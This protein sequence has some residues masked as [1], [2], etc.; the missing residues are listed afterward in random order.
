M[1]IGEIARQARVSKSIIRYYE[2]KGV[3]PPAARDAKG[4]RDYG[5]SELRRIRLITGLRRMRCSFQDIKQTMTMVDERC[6]PSAEVL[7][8]LARKRAEAR[9]EM[10]RLSY[11]QA[12]L[13]RLDELAQTLVSSEGSACSHLELEGETWAGND[14][15]EEPERYLLERSATIDTGC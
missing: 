15:L 8:L 10:E 4:N 13:S 6:T 14:K 1:K 12:E 5:T 9:S 2:G 7:D 11:I 3:L